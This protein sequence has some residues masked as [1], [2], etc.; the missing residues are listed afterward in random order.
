ME[1]FCAVKY[2]RA[3]TEV[4]PSSCGLA[5]SAKHRF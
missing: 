5:I 2:I 1:N 3:F 4:C